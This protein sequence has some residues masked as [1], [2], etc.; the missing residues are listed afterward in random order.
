VVTP[1]GGDVTVEQSLV[2]RCERIS[3]EE[4]P[5]YRTQMEQMARFLDEELVLEPTPV[6]VVKPARA[7][8]AR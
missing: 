1:N 4:Y 6:P 3:P 8:R 5:A 7:V 2:S